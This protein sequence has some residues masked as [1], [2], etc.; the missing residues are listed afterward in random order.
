[1]R[2]IKIDQFEFDDPG[3]EESLEIDLSR[4]SRFP[5]PDVKAFVAS[6]VGVAAA[7]SLGNP[8]PFYSNSHRS[9]VAEYLKRFAGVDVPTHCDWPTYEL[10]KES[11]DQAHLIICTPGVF[12]RYQWST[13][14]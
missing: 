1:V 14:A 5:H 11:W 7:S 10:E 4:K 3:S 6:A 9:Q 2:S 8:V 12:V 13:S